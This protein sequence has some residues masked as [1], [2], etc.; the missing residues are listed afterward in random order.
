MSRIIGMETTPLQMSLRARIVPV[1]TTML[2]SM[3]TLMPFV[4]TAPMVPPAGLLMLLGW[5]LLRPEI[6]PVWAAL[7]LGLW[8]DLFSGQPLGTAML[9]WTLSFMA[10]DLADK[11]IVWRDYW[12]D[13]FIAAGAIAFCI[14]AG[15]LIALST[16]GG[17]YILI[18]VPQMIASMLL[19]PIV[20]R[21]CALFDHWR[22]MR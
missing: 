21:A 15:F 16:G 6:W 5:R 3:L 19:F 9:T 7:P 17:G 13:W 11:W 22:L 18:I 4:A 12:L 20:A 2:A 8:D 10:I 1:A 14:I